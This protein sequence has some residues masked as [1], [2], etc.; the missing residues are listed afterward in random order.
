MTRSLDV[1]ALSTGRLPHQSASSWSLL[2]GEIQLLPHGR[3][4]AL[5]VHLLAGQEHHLGVRPHRV[6]QLVSF[7][8]RVQNGLGGQAGL[9]TAELVLDLG[10][11]A[12]PLLDERL[13]V[14]GTPRAFRGLWF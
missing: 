2:P 10:K 7:L 13:I 11:A 8:Y 5:V 1:M 6:A 9:R 12:R 14:G 4:K 3:L